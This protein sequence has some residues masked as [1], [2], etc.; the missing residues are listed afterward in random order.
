MS[1]A[2]RL[3]LRVLAAVL[4]ALV[5]VIA[6]SLSPWSTATGLLVLGVLPTLTAAPSGVRAMLIAAGGSVAT[7]FVAVLLAQTGGWAPWLGTGLV[8]LLS[9]ATGALVLRGLHPVGA[10]AISFAAYVLVDPSSV[11]RFLD[12]RSSPWAAAAMVAGL[13]VLG[14]GWAI[15]AVATVLRGVRLPPADRSTPTLPYGM[16]LAVLCGL[17][18]LVCALW[19]PGT[20]AWWAVMTVAV[21]LQPSHGETRTKLRGRIVGTVL[22]GTA[23]ALIVLILPGPLA[24][25]LLGVAASLASVVLLL[26]GAAYWRYSVAVTMSVILLTFERSEVI[27]GDLQ[28]ITVTVVAAAVTAA[29][30]WLAARLTPERV[31]EGAGAQPGPDLSPRRPPG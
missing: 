14:C 29:A 24:G 9:L 13:V 28:R 4:L 7:A 11:I 21:I 31:L 6:M 8:V 1:T 17:F 2:S 20:N 27:A 26:S 18:T 30:V 3:V 5:P 19:F 23:A 22:G 15:G 25:V 16:L 12:A 10:A